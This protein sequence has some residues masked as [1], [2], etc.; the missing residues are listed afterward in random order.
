MRYWGKYVPVAQ[1][2]AKA[3]RQL[4]KLRKQ[5]KA[6]LPVAI[7]GRNIARTF[8]GKGW[9]DHLESFSDYANRLPRGRTYVRNGS[10]C[11]LE[12]APGRIEALVIGSALY[13]VAINIRPLMSDKWGAI[14]K[15]CAGQIGSM[16]ELLQGKMSDQVMAIVTDRTN[17]L[18][19]Q[20]GEI[21]LDCSCPD[22]A[23]MCKHVAAVLYAVGSRLDSHPELLFELRAVDAQELIG[24]P[25]ALPT[26]GADTAGNTLV[27]EQLADIFGIDIETGIDAAAN[28][29]APQLK[30]GP[31][32]AKRRSSPKKQAQQV[33][34]A[35]VRRP[36][37]KTTRTPETDPPPGRVKARRPP[38]PP[39]A[40][41]KIKP[42]T[43]KG[44]ARLRKQLGLTVAQFAATLGVTPPTVY[45]WEGTAGKLKLQQRPLRA[46]EAIQS[47][48]KK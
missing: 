16:L 37:S 14:K 33:P 9:C 35:K 6:V 20:P 32:A 26:T 46:L 38:S 29:A 48:L 8:W 41:R 34:A 2:R 13:Q 27:D 12:I 5:G 45:R 7:E 43:G 23:L 18:F 11:H 44:L 4:N 31:P 39:A 15:K 22:W 30:A 24:A 10:V 36:S 25:M 19:P 28:P 42:L 40:A 21:E 17:G 47:K 3:E 1:R